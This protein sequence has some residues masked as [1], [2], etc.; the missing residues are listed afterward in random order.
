[1]SRG[2]AHGCWLCAMCWHDARD[3]GSHSLPTAGA[4]DDEWV[5]DA[6]WW[7]EPRVVL[8]PGKE[9]TASGRGCG[10]S[11]GRIDGCQGNA[12]G[13]EVGS[14]TLPQCRC[15][16][17]RR[18]FSCTRSMQPSTWEVLLSLLNMVSLGLTTS[19]SLLSDSV[20][21]ATPLQVH[22]RQPLP[23]LPGRPSPSTSV[24]LPPL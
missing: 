17:T 6:L 23:S 18:C 13:W 14:P 9:R 3:R 22:L 19:K 5:G 10:Q 12:S 4:G 15:P 21:R 24:S 20:T 7:K 11:R 1:M 8:T 16:L 2:P